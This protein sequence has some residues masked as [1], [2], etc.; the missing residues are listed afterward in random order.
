MAVRET[1]KSVFDI[2]D[3]HTFSAT[4]CFLC[5]KRLNKRNRTDEDVIPKWLQRQFA[6]QNQTVTLLNKTKLRYRELKIPCCTSCNNHHLSKLENRMKKGLFPTSGTP[7]VSKH[8]LFCWLAKIMYGIIYRE[9]HLPVDRA[10]PDLGPIADKRGLD[11]FRNMLLM[12]HSVRVRFHCGD[13]DFP[14]SVFVFNLAQPATVAARFDLRDD[15]ENKAIALR[16]GTKGILAVFDGGVQELVVGDLFR[17]DGRRTLHPVQFEE[18]AA[19]LF[20]KASLLDS[21]TKYLF[22]ESGRHYDVAVM[23]GE[24][25]SSRPLFKDWNMDEYAKYLSLFT[26]HPLSFVNP[27]PGLVH[28]WLLTD[29]NDEP[30]T[31]DIEQEPWRGVA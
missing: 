7:H 10:Q 24:G 29:E 13:L 8:D 3:Q 5:A 12:L 27:K 2:I 21:S 15:L 26:L 25:Y 1:R 23:C 4:V 31:I 28:S 6:L 30:I 17:K 18:L 20:Y 19:K 22:A 14:A 16:L 9:L 11:S